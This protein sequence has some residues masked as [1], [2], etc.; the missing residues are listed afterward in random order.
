MRDNI[1]F[2]QFKLQLSDHAEQ[3]ENQPPSWYRHPLYPYPR[4]DRE[5]YRCEQVEFLQ[6]IQ[7]LTWTVVDAV[8]REA[9]LV[10]RILDWIA[11]QRPR[12]RK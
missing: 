10:N 6:T 12:T 1:T 8:S 4:L 11:L 9:M 3:P 2:Y 5:Q 7:D